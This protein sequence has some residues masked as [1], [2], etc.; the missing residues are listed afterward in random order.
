MVK[1][2][3]RRKTPRQTVVNALI[4]SRAPHNGAPITY[5][6]LLTSLRRDIARAKEHGFD[7]EKWSKLSIVAA[8]R[9]VIQRNLLTCPEAAQIIVGR[10]EKDLAR[11]LVYRNERTASYLTKVPK[12]VKDMVDAVPASNLLVMLAGMA[13]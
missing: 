3:S 11:L 4:I 12:R 6:E 9:F 7:F 10:P 13:E 5:D 2:M 1:T 8:L